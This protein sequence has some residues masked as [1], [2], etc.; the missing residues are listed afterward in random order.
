MRN[1][2]ALTIEAEVGSGCNIHET[3]REAI[4]VAN[5]LMVNIHFKFNDIALTICPDE[6]ITDVHNMYANFMEQALAEAENQ[7]REAR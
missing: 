6:T 4:H 3:F 5:T 2:A 7:S 1:L